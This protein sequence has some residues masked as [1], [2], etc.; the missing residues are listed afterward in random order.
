[1]M[2]RSEHK[3]QSA[4]LVG[5]IDAR[6]LLFRSEHKSQSAKLSHTHSAITDIVPVRAQIPIC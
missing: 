1:M 2:F 4:K 5:V 3:S 6:V